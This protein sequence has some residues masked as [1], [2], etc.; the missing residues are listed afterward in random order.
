MNKYKIPCCDLNS[1]SSSKTVYILYI[2]TVLFFRIRYYKKK[3]L[4]LLQYKNRIAKK[5]KLLVIMF[6]VSGR[7]TLKKKIN[8]NK[9]AIPKHYTRKSHI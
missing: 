9:T 8:L 2:Y 1:Q 3:E 5:K 7:L 4:N 6:Y